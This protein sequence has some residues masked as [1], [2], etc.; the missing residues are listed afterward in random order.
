MIGLVVHAL[1]IVAIGAAIGCAAVL[2][3][4]LSGERLSGQ[5][6]KSSSW[7]A[8]AT[9]ASAF[10]S[11]GMIEYVWDAMGVGGLV[12]LGVLAQFGIVAWQQR[13]RESRLYRDTLK[14]TDSVPGSLDPTATTEEFG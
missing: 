2:F 8:G 9:S 6:R 3:E 4:R 5:G 1:L 14:G 12:A 7:W 11:V 13:R 10:M